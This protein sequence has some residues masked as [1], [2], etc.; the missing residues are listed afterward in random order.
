MNSRLMLKE[1]HQFERA[2]PYYEHKNVDIDLQ[3]VLYLAAEYYYWAKSI[4]VIYNELVND[5]KL[6]HS[7][8]IKE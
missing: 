6:N 8:Q 4:I 5:L 1:N 3:N 7:Y 2:S